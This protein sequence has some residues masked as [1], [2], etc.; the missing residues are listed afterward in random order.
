[1]F[2]WELPPYN[3][4]GLGVA[5]L[6][7]ARG[8]ASLGVQVVFVLPKKVDVDY[9]FMKVTYAE[10]TANLRADLLCAY[11]SKLGGAM[12]GPGMDI[13]EQEAAYA[14]AVD[15]VIA[16]EKCDI[17]HGH[18]WLCFGAS[19]RAKMKNGTPMI[20]QVHATEYDRTGGLGINTRIAQREKAGLLVADRIVAVSSYTRRLI[21]EQYG[22]APDK[23]RVV[24][25]GINSEDYPSALGEIVELKRHGYKI[26]LSVG[27]ITAQKGLDY[28]VRV[29]NRVLEFC[30]KTFFL[31]AGDGEMKPQLIRMVAEMGLSDK[32]LFPGFAR[33]EELTKLFRSADVFMMPSVSEPFG[34]VALE[35][36]HFGT[37]VV[38]S[39]QS[40]VAEVS[41][42]SLKSDFWD[43]DNMVNQVV[44]VLKYPVLKRSLT[45][46]SKRDVEKLSW[47]KMAGKMLQVYQEVV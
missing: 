3:S 14:A 27:R 41:G 30:P 17:V 8:L 25:N 11:Q 10:E 36:L 33:G 43:V 20:A 18:D 6:G 38:M 39:K 13:C 7:I 32:V 22:I 40:G 46:D 29:A 1:M 37:P 24:H 45:S 42:G 9:P 23:V 16:S 47:Q 5:S 28:F 2:G 35:A 34:I 21:Q 4:G 12:G 26:V 19:V 15:R 44:A 31:I